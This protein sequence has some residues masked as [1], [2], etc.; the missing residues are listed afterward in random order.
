MGTLAV[1]GGAYAMMP[2]EN[3]QATPPGMAAP[4]TPQASAGCVS[5]GASGASGGG[6]SRSS[7]LSFYGGDSSSSRA[8]AS[9]DSSSGSVTRGGFGSFARVRLFRP[10]LTK[11]ALAVFKACTM[12]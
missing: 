12:P 5:R 3:C 7:P 9:S 1:G 10:R 6:Y 8:S 2:R 11:V 4:T